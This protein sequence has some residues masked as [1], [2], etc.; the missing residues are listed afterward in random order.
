MKN[1]HTGERWF[2]AHDAIFTN[3]GDKP[4]CIAHIDKNEPSTSPADREANARLIA[5]APEL[6]EALERVLK[7]DSIARP[8]DAFESFQLAEKAI[9]KAKGQQ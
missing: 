3:G 4:I 6:L 1:T 7:V 9:A 8:I 2:V 5:A